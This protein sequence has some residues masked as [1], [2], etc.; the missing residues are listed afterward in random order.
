MNILWHG[1]FCLFK[2]KITSIE[3]SFIQCCGHEMLAALLYKHDVNIVPVPT[4]ALAL[5]ILNSLRAM[6][7]LPRIC[8]YMIDE[9]KYTVQI[10]DIVPNSVGDPWQ[11]WKVMKKLQKSRIQGF[12]YYFCLMM[13]GSEAGSGSGAESVLVTNGSGCGSGRPKNIRIL[14]I[15]NTGTQEEKFFWNSTIFRPVQQQD[16]G[17][18]NPHCLGLE[19]I[20]PTRTLNTWRL[21]NSWTVRPSWSSYSTYCPHVAFSRVNI[22]KTADRKLLRERKHYFPPG[23]LVW[24]LFFLFFVV[25]TVL[26]FEDKKEVDDMIRYLP[27]RDAK[28]K[29]EFCHQQTFEHSVQEPAQDRITET[30]LLYMCC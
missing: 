18:P 19:R 6:L 12:S 10:V 1:F 26:F 21:C 3:K 25:T 15:P 30:K 5:K 23:D 16:P 14:R 8:F 20:P 13:E 17:G 4:L 24:Y 11:S 2:I 28:R 27:H 22:F 9:V 7:E 29:G